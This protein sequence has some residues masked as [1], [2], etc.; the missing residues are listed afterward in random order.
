MRTLFLGSLRPYMNPTEQ[1]LPEVLSLLG[2][3]ETLHPPQL[4]EPGPYGSWGSMSWLEPQPDAVILDTALTFGLALSGP[5]AQLARTIRLRLEDARSLGV[6]V[7]ASLLRMDPHAWEPSWNPRLIGLADAFLGLDPR[8]APS[9]EARALAALD[10]SFRGL[11]SMSYFDFV[12]DHRDR[13][14]AFPHFVSPS[15]D[16]EGLAGLRSTKEMRWA[17]P[18]AR[19]AERRLA[20]QELLRIRAK[21]RV[22]RVNKLL[23]ASYRLGIASSVAT[24]FARHRYKMLIRNADLVF[25]SGS[26]LKLPVRKYFEVPALGRLMVAEPFNGMADLGFVPGRHFVESLSGDLPAID[27]W[28]R[29][30]PD[31]ALEIAEQGYSFVW[32][33]HSSRSRADMLRAV[34]LAARDTKVPAIEWRNGVWSLL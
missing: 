13:L 32:D 29:H 6:P 10:S 11:L 30:N 19:Y 33:R 4:T 8:H 22:S 25:V 3:V 23:A 9:L 5:D 2:E 12:H 24:R 20:E 17:I 16:F 28:A 26:A 31:S 14:I 7:I 1:L 15:T 21:V 34:L 27:S 18:G